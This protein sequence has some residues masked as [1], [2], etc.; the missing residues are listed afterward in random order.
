MAG[1]PKIIKTCTNR[2]VARRQTIHDNY[3]TPAFCV[4]S[5]LKREIDIGGVVLDPCSGR[6][7]TSKEILRLKPETKIIASDIR[8]GPDIYGIGGVDF[9]A[10]DNIY[11][12]FTEKKVADWAVFNP[13][14]R[15]STHFLLNA[16]ALVRTGVAIFQRTQWL[17]SKGRYRDIWSSTPFARAWFFVERVGCFREGEMVDPKTGGMLAFAWYIFRV[18]YYRPATIGWITDKPD[19]THDT[20]LVK[21]K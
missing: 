14:F 8:K 2:F 9:L 6:G 16:L 11:R 1:S 20:R 7:A 3:S 5:L 10:E 17:E 21:G 12:G 4:E 19:F 15:M 18:G 13:P